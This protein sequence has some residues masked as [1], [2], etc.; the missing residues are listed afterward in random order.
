MVSSHPF[1][2][3]RAGVAVKRG[4]RRNV[5]YGA[6]TSAASGR[7]TWMSRSGDS[8]DSAAFSQEMR[9]ENLGVRVDQEEL[10][11]VTVAARDEGL[12]LS[13]RSM[14]WLLVATRKPTGKDWRCE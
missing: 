13:A 3:L 5:R 11:E 10:A 7:A 6:L 8:I 4:R 1:E 9:T 12:S 2:E 14:R